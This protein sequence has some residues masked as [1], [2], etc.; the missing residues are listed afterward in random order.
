[1]LKSCYKL[2]LMSTD[3][4]WLIQL[5]MM[6]AIGCGRLQLV[7]IGW[8]WLQLVANGYDWLWLVAIS[9]NWCNWLQFLMFGDAFEEEDASIYDNW[10]LIVESGR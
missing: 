5:V 9:Y 1:M 3:N 6:V 10:M 4:H 7:V 8:D 2:W